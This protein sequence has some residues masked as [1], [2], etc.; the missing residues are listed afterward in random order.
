MAAWCLITLLSY[1]T[2]IWYGSLPE[3]QL[4]RLH[5]IASVFILGGHTMCYMGWIWL[6]ATPQRR[7]PILHTAMR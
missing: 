3:E 5:A 1:F 6:W 7:W 4:N 2:I